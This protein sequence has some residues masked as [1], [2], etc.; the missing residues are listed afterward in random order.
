MAPVT[1]SPGM[2]CSPPLMP[3]VVFSLKVEKKE[4]ARNGSGFSLGRGRTLCCYF[5]LLGVFELSKLG[6]IPAKQVA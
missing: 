5:L 6:L 1:V 3:V 2:P 4:N